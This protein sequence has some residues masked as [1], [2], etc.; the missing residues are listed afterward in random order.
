MVEMRFWDLDIQS[1]LSS[2][3]SGIEE[4]AKFAERLGFS[5]IVICDV[6]Q[7]SEKLHAL[8]E[9]IAEVQKMFKIEILPGAKIEAKNS[10]ELKHAL[11]KVRDSVVVVA[12]AGGVYDINRAACEDSR[13]D[14]LAHPEF[15]RF[16][17]GLDEP[18]LNAAVRNNVAIEINFRQILNSYR[19]QRAIIL[20]KIAT[21]VYLCEETG[22][23]IVTASG[24]QSVWEMR[25]AREL[26][27]IANV[28]GLEFGKSF[29]TI[30]DTPNA[31][32]ESNKK[33]LSGKIVTEGVEILE[34]ENKIKE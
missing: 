28:L 2:G 17:N 34:Q 30:E 25:D 13:V 18:C 8:K 3:S 14:I 9:K 31:I 19:R 12:V 16:D 15:G 24:A 20:N 4:I 33:K 10:G 21:N 7:N 26:I 32:V 11:E 29:S 1:N 6:W 27:S 22:A 23:K 5:G